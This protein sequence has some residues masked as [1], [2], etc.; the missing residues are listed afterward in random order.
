MD[1]AGNWSSRHGSTTYPI[2]RGQEHTANIAQKELLAWCSHGAVL[3]TFSWKPAV[4]QAAQNDPKGY[5]SHRDEGLPRS[6]GRCPLW[7]PL[8]SKMLP[9]LLPVALNYK[10]GVCT[11]NNCLWHDEVASSIS[12]H[13]TQTWEISQTPDHSTPTPPKKLFLNTRMMLS[14]C[15]NTNIRAMSW[16]CCSAKEISTSVTNIPS[17]PPRFCYRSEVKQF[18]GAE[19]LHFCFVFK[20]NYNLIKHTGFVPSVMW[21]SL[22]LSGR[23]ATKAL[24][25]FL[26]VLCGT[27]SCHPTANLITTCRPS[28]ESFCVVSR[29]TEF[30]HEVV[31]AL[32]EN[33]CTPIYKIYLK[34]NTL[35]TKNTYLHPCVS[36]ELISEPKWN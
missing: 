2:Q 27:L 30:T 14:L 36:F 13:H 7:L 31:T 34:T 26:N 21:L 22:P 11:P 20:G 24:S 28:G 15:C 17:S 6:I 18:N 29:R 23:L 16:H 12:N 25:S 9:N 1:R 33:V 10:P 8:G 32:T 3:C 19:L 35:A 5:N 4:T